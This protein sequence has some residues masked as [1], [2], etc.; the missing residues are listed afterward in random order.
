MQFADNAIWCGVI[1]VGHRL[2]KDFHH[3]VFAVGN[4]DSCPRDRP[5]PRGPL[6]PVNCAI[7]VGLLDVIG[8]IVNEDAIVKCVGKKE[9][10]FGYQSP[11]RA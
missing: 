11:Y 1:V 5:P 3:G 2:E 4:I 7:G 6:K 9:V 10:V 8:K